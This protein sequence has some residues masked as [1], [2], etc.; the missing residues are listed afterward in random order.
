MLRLEPPAPSQPAPE[1][2]QPAVAVAPQPAAA[3]PQAQPKPAPEPAAVA[4][5]APAQQP[6]AAAAEPAAEPP[7]APEP[8]AAQVQARPAAPDKP[9]AAEPALVQPEPEPVA[10][11]EQPPAAAA[12][13]AAND[14]L[15]ADNTKLLQLA[16]AKYLA[17][18]LPGAETMLRRAL[19]QEPDDHHVAEELVRVL[20]DRG[21]GAEAVK[22]AA[23]I[24]RKRPKRVSYRIL[25]GDA[26]LLAG[27]R[28]AAEAAWREALAIE[29]ENRDAKRRL[30]MR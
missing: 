22:Y 21:R 8:A 17:N 30:G 26:K 28:P 3:E 7:P 11:P 14:S 23:D 24:V 29:P 16:H 5:P 13:A 10:E 15:P 1:P 25:D 2:T 20:I 6:A 9:A 4:E 12:P 19:G 27:D 18:D